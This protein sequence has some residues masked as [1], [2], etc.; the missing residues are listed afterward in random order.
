MS[1]HSAPIRGELPRC[2]AD[3]A[4]RGSWIQWRRIWQVR[5]ARHSVQEAALSNRQYVAI[6]VAVIVVGF[7]TLAIGVSIA[8]FTAI[9][10]LDA[11]GRETYSWV[12]RG[13]VYTT[14]GQILA[15]TGVFMIMGGTT[16]GFLYKRPMT[17]ARAA[18]GASLFAGLQIIF[19][20][21]IPN[22]MLTLTQSELEW[23]SQNIALT[24]P[25]ALTLGSEIQISYAVIKDML[26]Q[27]WIITA[28]IGTAVVMVMWQ[29]RQKKKADAPPPAPV[30]VYGR[31]LVKKGS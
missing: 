11:L 31:P 5:C 27:G 15:L 21:V 20:G 3:T 14:G 30:S 8:H 26:V 18:L 12:P 29:D 23:S 4:P 7:I 24:L 17:W 28:L 19:F 9:E 2:A 1:T 25:T 6:G 13:W 10:E 22:Q 16:F